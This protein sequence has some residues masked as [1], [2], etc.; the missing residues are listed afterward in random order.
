MVGVGWLSG[1]HK[2]AYLS[3]RY[4]T[5]PTRESGLVGMYMAIVLTLYG[6]SLPR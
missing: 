5:Q 6:E 1:G 3:R 4:A 2:T